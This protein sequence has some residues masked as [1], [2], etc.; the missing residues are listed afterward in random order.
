LNFF[1]VIGTKASPKEPV[2]PVINI[3]EFESILLC[4]S[5]II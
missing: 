4:P 5:R 3:E 2:P 1:R